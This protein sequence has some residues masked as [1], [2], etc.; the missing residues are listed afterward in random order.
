MFHNRRAASIPFGTPASSGDSLNFNFLG[1]HRPITS[2]STSYTQITIDTGSTSNN[3]TISG[4]SS[5]DYWYILGV[6][7]RDSNGEA[8]ANWTTSF[9]IGGTTAKRIGQW[10]QSLAN[11]F[12]TICF[13]AYQTTS[14]N[15][16]GTITLN[17]THEGGVAFVLYEFE[18]T[19]SDLAYYNNSVGASGSGSGF[20]SVVNGKPTRLWSD[21]PTQTNR[22]WAGTRIHSIWSNGT[23]NA[24][25]ATP[26]GSSS[27]VPTWTS[28]YYIEHGTAEYS[29]W[30]HGEYTGSSQTYTQSSTGGANASSTQS[31][32]VNIITIGDV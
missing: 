27:G 17:A 11:S 28:D 26:V 29:R 31:N 7:S 19:G 25:A 12:T 1:R 24:T 8:N 2:T 4:I 13:Y 22:T 16:T 15:H 5:E 18:Y 9:S 21:H 20:I 14:T 3:N 30:Y 32:A 6:A 23:S 10:P